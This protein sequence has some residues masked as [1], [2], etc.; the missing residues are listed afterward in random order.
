MILGSQLA[1]ASVFG[2]PQPS[3]GKLVV[4]GA[5]LAASQS[6]QSRSQ[7][8]K[9]NNRDRNDEIEDTWGLIREAMTFRVKYRLKDDSDKA[10]A[11]KRLM[12]TLLCVSRYNRGGSYPNPNTVLNLLISIFDQGFNDADANHEGVAVQEI[13]AKDRPDDYVTDPEYNIEN[14]SSR[15]SKDL[16]LIHI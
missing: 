10:R 3:L 1:P 6:P 16:S 4:A 15:F 12:L 2:A 9:V 5:K 13:P 7:M 14:V 8:P 11:K